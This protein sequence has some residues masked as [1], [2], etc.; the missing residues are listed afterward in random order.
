MRADEPMGSRIAA[1][2]WGAAR[3][4][5]AGKVNFTWPRRVCQRG[6]KGQGLVFCGLNPMSGPGASY[7]LGLGVA[8]LLLRRSPHSVGSAGPGI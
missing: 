6:A 4:M 5:Q 1:I 2:I 7:D 3:P 8:A